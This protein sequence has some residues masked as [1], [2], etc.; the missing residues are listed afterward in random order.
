[1]RS[2]VGLTSGELLF[3]LKQ[4]HEMFGKED[5][6]RFTHELTEVLRTRWRYEPYH[7]RLELLHIVG[8]VRD[9]EET[10]KAALIEAING[11][12]I[13]ASNWALNSSVIDALKIL[14]AL[15]DEGEE[16]RAAIHDEVA[17]VIGEADSDDIREQALSV[18][19]RMFDHPFDW[20]YAEEV[21]SLPED[22]QRLL[23]RRAF[24]ANGIG[25]SMSVR[26][27]AERIVEYEEPSDVPL[28]SNLAQLPS[29]TN[30]MSQDE[31]AAFALAVR[32]LARHVA[33]LP[34]ADAENDAQECMVLVRTL[35]YAAESG[36]DADLKEARVAWEGLH[37]LPPQLVI[38]CLAEMNEPL[39]AN[40]VGERPPNY[41]ALSLVDV[42]PIDLLEVSRK[43]IDEGMLPTSYHRVG[44]GDRD[45]HFAFD[46]VAKHGDRSDLGRLRRVSAGH[47]FAQ[48][49]IE[50]IRAIET[51]AAATS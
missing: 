16:Q 19:T 6:T 33:P 20:I 4:R 2:L 38:G 34:A 31:M 49:A 30:P 14:G 40:H 50:V 44:F 10:V 47:P 43:L 12:E 51:A 37:A 45:L 32:F 26:Y 48:K 41:P 36:R 35:V 11:L 1:M 3:V 8:F 24:Q 39:A 18:Y 29:Q 42:F 28:F 23:Y 21:Y 15:D 5:I 27:L 25:D 46:V 9:A 22:T 17:A 7:V 13:H